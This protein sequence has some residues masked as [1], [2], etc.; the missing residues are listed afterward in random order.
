MYSY[1]IVLYQL[2]TNGHAPF[3]ELSPYERDKA[4][5]EV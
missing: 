4:V 2:I 5:E 3:E 1:G